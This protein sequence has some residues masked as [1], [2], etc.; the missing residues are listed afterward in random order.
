M[1]VNSGGKNYIELIWGDG[2]LVL[3]D[4]ADEELGLVSRPRNT[5]GYHI[6]RLT[7]WNLTGDDVQRST[8]YK[9]CI[10]P[11]M[12]IAVFTGCNTHFIFKTANKMGRVSIIQVVGNLFYG[13][14]RFCQ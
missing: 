10:H 11:F 7:C 14:C 5:H 12:L 4:N 2:V 9:L 3:E 13:V 6:T 8:C 1:R